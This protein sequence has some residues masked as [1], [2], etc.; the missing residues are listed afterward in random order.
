MDDFLSKPLTPELGE[1]LF[2]FVDDRRKSG[3]SLTPHSPQST[4]PCLVAQA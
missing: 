3:G 4:T 2:Q 1:K